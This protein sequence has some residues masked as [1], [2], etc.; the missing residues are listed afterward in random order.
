MNSFISGW[1][2]AN[3]VNF[4]RPSCRRKLVSTFNSSLPSFFDKNVNII[5]EHES[6]QSCIPI[7]MIS[8]QKKNKS[9][10]NHHFTITLTPKWSFQPGGH[11]RLELLHML[12]SW[13]N[14]SHLLINRIE[15]WCRRE[16]DLVMDQIVS[17][18]PKIKDDRLSSKLPHE[19]QLRRPSSSY[20]R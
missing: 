3:R 2:R 9:K 7:Q 16:W 11:E 10:M 17:L 18:F 6:L 20:P 5:N 4:C 1:Q 15:H 13:N 8:W 19:L 12:P 14:G